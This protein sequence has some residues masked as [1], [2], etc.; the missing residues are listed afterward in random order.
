MRE[1]SNIRI[2]QRIGNRKNKI[3]NTLGILY[4]PQNLWI[5]T[6]M[7][8][9]ATTLNHFGPMFLF[10]ALWKYENQW[11]SDVFRGYTK[12]KWTWNGLKLN[13][14]SVN[15]TKWPYIL[16]QSRWLLSTNC[17]SVFDH[18]AGLALNGLKRWQK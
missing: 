18:F 11:F 6:S 1:S 2:Y 17:L 14:L 12:R 9:C 8:Y 13:P 16:K 15:P 10:D 3:L 4:I 5:M 7:N